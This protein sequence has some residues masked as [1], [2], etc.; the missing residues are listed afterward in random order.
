M[1]WK[2]SPKVWVGGGLG[3]VPGQ[4]EAAPMGRGPPA[5]LGGAVLPSGVAARGHSPG[6]SGGRA[7]SA[8]GSA[9]ATAAA[10]GPAPPPPVLLALRCSGHPTS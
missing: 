8:G 3:K 6:V 7:H 10:Q 2:D 5:G 4:P 9:A 1:P